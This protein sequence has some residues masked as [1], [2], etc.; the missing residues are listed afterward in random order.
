MTKKQAI[1]IL[2]ATAPQAWL[3]EGMAEAH[4]RGA[5]EDVLEA[6]DHAGAFQSEESAAEIGRCVR[7]I[8]RIDDARGQDRAQPHPEYVFAWALRLAT[9]CRAAGL[10]KP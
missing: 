8:E 1:E 9:A 6:L 4:A 3:D 5:C 7:E 10:V 2:N